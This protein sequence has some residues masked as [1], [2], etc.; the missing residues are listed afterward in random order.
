MRPL[1]DSVPLQF[2]REKNYAP[3]EREWLM[4]ILIPNTMYNL[5]LITTSC[6]GL[7]H[8]TVQVWPS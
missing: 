3:K 4:L 5:T 7:N 8:L 2:I 1:E 6:L